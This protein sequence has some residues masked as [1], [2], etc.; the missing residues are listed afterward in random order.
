MLLMDQEIGIQMIMIWDQGIQMGIIIM[1]IL[2]L[3]NI[4]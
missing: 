1:E 4:V 3:L 2:C